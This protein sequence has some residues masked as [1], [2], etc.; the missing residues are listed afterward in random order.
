M[1]ERYF[2][3]SQEEFSNGHYQHAIKKHF[4][5]MDATEFSR[6]SSLGGESS[7]DDFIQP[8]YKETY[9]LAIDRLVDGG[10]DTYDEFLKDERVKSFLSEDEL[11][12]ITANVKRLTPKS[13]TEDV[14]GS[15]DA[16]SSS[17]TYWPIHSDVQTP[18]LELGWPEILP[19]NLHT[20]INLLF[21]PPRMN[22][23]TIKEVI[24]K[25]IQD[26]KQ[27]I[28]IVMDVFTDVDIFKETMDASLRGVPVYVLLDELHY[29]SFVKMAEDQE[30]K[31]QQLRNMMV[32]TVKGQEYL[33]R[34][35]ATFHGAMEQKFLVVD[36][37]T[38]IYGSY[39]FSWSFEKIHL[40]MVQVIKGH[41]VK[42][43]DEEFRTLYAQSTVP[44]D[45][46]P[47]QGLCLNSGLHIRQ[48][49]LPNSQSAPKLGRRDQLRY[50]FDMVNRKTCERRF[51]TRD[52]KDESGMLGPVI[53][54]DIMHRQMLQF[55]QISSDSMDLLKRHSYAGERQDGQVP[56]NIRPKGSNW[57]IYREMGTGQ[58]N[59]AVDNYQQV[60]H[61]H[62]GQNMRQSYNGNDKQVF[63]M[64]QNLPALED[65][66]MAY[67]QNWS[68]GA[69]LKNSVS[70][71][72]DA[73]DYLDQ[74][75]TSD[76]AN[77]FMQGRMRNSL[78]LRSTIME[79][80]EPKIH[81]NIPAAPISPLHYS[82]MQWNP[83]FIENR[84]NSHDFTVKRQSLQILD[85]SQGS[86]SLGPCRNSNPYTFASLG[87][88][89]HGQI[90]KTPDLLTDSW[91]KRHSLAES[92][93]NTESTR[94]PPTPT[95]GPYIR[96]P[97]NK[98]TVEISATSERHRSNLGE[99]QRSISHYDVNSN[100]DTKGSSNSNWQEPP[101][102]T[103]S[104][105]ALVHKNKDLTNKSNSTQR[106]RKNDSTKS[107]IDIPE[108]KGEYL[109]SRETTPSLTSDESTSTI[110]AE[111]EAETSS[112]RNSHRST[113]A[114]DRFSSEHSKSQSRTEEHLLPWQNS[115]TKTSVQK[116]P[117]FR[118]P[119]RL[120]Q[121][122]SSEKKPSM[123]KNLRRTKSEDKSK[124]VS[125]AEA[126]AEYN[127][128]QAARGQQENKLEKFFH[129]IGNFMNKN[130]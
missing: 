40:S 29:K 47:P 94:E 75:E 98:S 59:Y 76:K 113:T 78:A 7:A 101:S 84:L 110:T 124:S 15:S 80:T 106:L 51:S 90:I 26:A 74:H 22:N 82:S 68:L 31:L 46:S 104:A 36:C 43:Y 64:Q 27:V 30:I 4:G 42:S 56:L 91:H 122:H 109:K 17:G 127:L 45:L 70:P 25:Y 5:E 61:M 48:P 119:S 63:S 87:R 116:K 60:S 1:E 49:L 33:C 103:V 69:F 129:R 102:R 79:Q 24:R 32:R 121:F 12:F 9:R 85:D 100:T 107:S 20:N 21:H 50:T 114:S 99:D 123:P 77:T 115:L 62:R 72:L 11:L 108:R 71:A 6:L 55:P 73:D 37:H 88:S 93:S 65:R 81:A 128:T 96:K 16:S 14:V 35:G 58:N 57:N 95:H 19:E 3:G 10:R 130:K 83:A 89:K 18:N 8:H 86:P 105:A 23:P 28:G 39:S 112:A 67:R 13:Q 117:S 118:L 66:P 34:S 44:A 125:K 38:A 53:E 52:L 54:N 41:L 92:H 97:L 126:A 2:R 111:D 120:E